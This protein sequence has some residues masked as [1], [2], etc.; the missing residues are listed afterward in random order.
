MLGGEIRGKPVM[1]LPGE[2][3]MGGL[4]DRS[5]GGRSIDPYQ[6]DGCGGRLPYR[7]QGDR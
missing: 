6:R 5:P 2:G 7:S 1:I 3:R 4:P